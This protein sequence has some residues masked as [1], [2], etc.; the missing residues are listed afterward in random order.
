MSLYSS[1]CVLY[2]Y[3]KHTSIKAKLEPTN[4]RK[5]KAIKIKLKVHQLSSN[6]L[7]FNSPGQCIF[8]TSAPSKT[9][10]CRRS[11]WYHEAKFTC[12]ILDEAYCSVKFSEITV[13]TVVWQTYM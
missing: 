11:Y 7:H 5:I 3:K 12:A 8:A 1:L 2:K 9:F 10:L 6:N 13:L 4:K